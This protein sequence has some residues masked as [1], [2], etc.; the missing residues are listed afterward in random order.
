[1]DRSPLLRAPTWAALALGLMSPWASSQASIEFFGVPGDKA[2]DLSADGLTV[3]GTLGTVNGFS[4]TSAGGL[5]VLPNSEVWG[6]S[7]DG[8]VL[9]GNPING[10][11]F[12]EGGVHEAGNWT[13]T[14]NFNQPGCDSSISHLFSMAD[15]GDTAVGMAW[16][17]CDVVATRWTAAGGLEMLP[18]QSTNHWGRANAVSGDGSVSV[19][20]ETDNGFQ[21]RAIVWW[22]DDAFE[23]LLEGTPGNP[24]GLGEV[25]HVNDDGSA[26]CGISDSTAFRWT[27]GGGVE[28]LPAAPSLFGEHYANAISDDGDVVVGVSLAFPTLNAWI[29][30]PGTG[31]VRLLDHLASQGLTGLS[32]AELGNATGVS[33]DGTKICGWGSSGAWLVTLDEPANPWSDVGNG[34]AGAQGVP[35]LTGAGPLTGGS[36]ATLTLSDGVPGGTTNVVIGLTRLDGA[37][38]GG[39]RVPAPAVGGAGLPLDPS[40]VFCFSF[41]WPLGV[42]SGVDT[43]W[44][45]WMQDASGVLGWSASNGLQGTTP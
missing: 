3:V 34:L 4:W 13:F 17:G 16:Q 36:L 20:W 45:H 21:R 43:W 15:D 28:L 10:S 1:M 37:F 40:G 19:G 11:G 2:I 22:P 30:T 23:F 26:L 33:P 24:T 12:A 42:P 39:G 8:S 41:N 27:A 14:G 29:W 6:A 35:T 32:A 44:Q 5:N 25:S 7:A 9:A 18:Q 31:T 38:K